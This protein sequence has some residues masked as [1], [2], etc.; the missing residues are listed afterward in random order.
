M[1]P[2]KAGTSPARSRAAPLAAIKQ[3]CL[4]V[5]PLSW[6]VKMRDEGR[7]TTGAR[8]YM[9]APVFLSTLLEKES[10]FSEHP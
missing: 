7:R 5:E 3:V 10:D 1:E 9:A 4:Q 6:N 8:E 2:W